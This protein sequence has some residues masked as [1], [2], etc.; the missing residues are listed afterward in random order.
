LSAIAAW[1]IE[2]RAAQVVVIPALNG[3]I[4]SLNVPIG[5]GVGGVL[6]LGGTPAANLA[7]QIVHANG[8]APL[9]LLVMA[10]EEGGG[11]QRLAPLVGSLPWPRQ[12]ADTMTTAQVQSMA[13]G[14]A[15]KMR[16]L[17]V[18]VDLAPVLDVDDGDGPNS[19]NPDGQR[20]FSGDPAAAARYGVA[21]LEGLRQGGVLPVVKHFPGLG[22]SSNNT[23]YG[24]A[25]TL[26]FSTL[27]ST[28]MA[29]FKAAVT[30]GAAG[31]MV[32]NAT[33]P[34]LTSGPATMS[35][36]AIQQVLRGQMAFSG[37]VITDSLSAGAIA[38]AHYSVPQAA[39]AAIE[40]GAD[41][42][43]FGSTLT[44]ADVALLSPANVAATTSSIVSAIVG[45]VR[46]GQLPESQL[47]QAVLKVLATKG[48]HLCSN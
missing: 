6:L 45:A 31:V 25:S 3:E 19:T 23:D 44:P 30:A 38:A 20:S 29:P 42:I 21:F 27:R 18:G 10:D 11:V 8:H 7:T 47:D 9:P 12:M 22:G 36:A 2:R 40:A 14:V 26:P 39:V 24:P 35:S 28:A 13:S 43:L 16:A 4:E 15:R 34:G 37:L 41:M 46:S 32:G 1:P 48:T 33:V 17:G 5:A